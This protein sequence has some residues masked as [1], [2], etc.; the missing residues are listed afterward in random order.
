MLPKIRK[1]YKNTFINLIKKVFLEL[2]LCILRTRLRRSL[3]IIIKFNP[4][5]ALI[6]E[7]PR[8]TIKRKKFA[9]PINT[10]IGKASRITTIGISKFLKSVRYDTCF[11]FL[12]D[13]GNVL[14]HS[15]ESEDK[16]LI[17][18]IIVISRKLKN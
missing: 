18:S 11:N 3:I 2:I 9:V 4:K 7:I 15:I 17:V 12:S 10:V 13:S 1:T 5:N 6:N 14:N 16:P 8:H